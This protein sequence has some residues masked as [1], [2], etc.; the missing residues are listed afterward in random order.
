MRS[1]ISRIPLTRPTPM[2]MRISA[3]LWRHAVTRA[4]GSSLSRAESKMTGASLSALANALLARSA[5]ASSC[6]TGEWRSRPW[7][8]FWFERWHCHLCLGSWHRQRC[9]LQLMAS[10]PALASRLEAWCLRPGSVS[11]VAPGARRLSRLR[12][13]R[14]GD[15]LF[16]GHDCVEVFHECGAGLLSITASMPPLL[17]RCEERLSLDLQCL[18][19]QHSPLLQQ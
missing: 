3:C 1:G 18:G 6:H 4:T 12:A 5:A 13:T 15:A 11:A 14:I 17:S 9:A 7:I 16:L 10:P 8:R 2:A 19:R